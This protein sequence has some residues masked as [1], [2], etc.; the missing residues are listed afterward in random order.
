[1]A[2]PE[3]AAAAWLAPIAVPVQTYKWN[4]RGVVE[5]EPAPAAP[6]DPK[7]GRTEAAMHPRGRPHRRQGPWLRDLFHPD[8]DRRS[9]DLTQVC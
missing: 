9:G 7:A 1:M 8:C 4:K 6:A 2:E 3:P 5:D